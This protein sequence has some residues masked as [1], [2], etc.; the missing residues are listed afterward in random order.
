MPFNPK[1]VLA[2]EYL[3]QPDY[4]GLKTLT[5]VAAEVGCDRTTLHRWMNDADFADELTRT[6]RNRAKQYV[7]DVMAAMVESA[8]KN[9]SANAAKLVLQA[10]GVLDNSVKVTHEDKRDTPTAHDVESL[11][12]RLV[13]LKARREAE[14]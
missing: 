1:Q 9:K 14:E 7:P 8:V 4:A 2:M 12:Q 11:R 3:S 10:A 5:A 6:M 13:D